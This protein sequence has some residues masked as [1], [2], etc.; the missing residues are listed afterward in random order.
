MRTE[1]DFTVLLETTRA[2]QQQIKAI[3]II[4]ML[5]HVTSKPCLPPLPVNG[6]KTL[7]DGSPSYPAL[8]SAVGQ[9]QFQALLPSEYTHL[10]LSFPFP[11][12]QIHYPVTA[13]LC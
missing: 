8:I 12:I 5:N 3:K 2:E 11:L 10:C 6:T 7:K 9:M 13:L 1:N 4:G